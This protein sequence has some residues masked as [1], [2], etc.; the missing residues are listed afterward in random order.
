MVHAT[1]CYSERQL[2]ELDRL[3]EQWLDDYQRK[4]QAARK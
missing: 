2:E 4:S 1:Q 3:T